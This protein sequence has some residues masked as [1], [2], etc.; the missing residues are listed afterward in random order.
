MSLG[1]KFKYKIWL[2]TS[3]YTFEQLKHD[4]ANWQKPVFCDSATSIPRQ[5]LYSNEFF[6]MDEV[7]STLN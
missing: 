5:V 7:Y 2:N 4:I 1:N 6:A 3:W